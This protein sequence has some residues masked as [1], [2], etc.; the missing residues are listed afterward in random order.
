[1][2]ILLIA[3][4]FLICPNYLFAQEDTYE[5]T[6]AKIDGVRY[7]AIYRSSD[8]SISILNADGKTVLHLKNTDYY[9][10]GFSSFKFVDFNGDGYKDLF[11]EHMSNVPG[12]CDLLLYDSRIKKFAPV[13]DFPDYPDPQKLK[14]THLYY[15]YHRSGCADMNWDS[16]L[17]KIV[18]N[19]II[20]IGNISGLGCERDKKMG[21][22]IS[23][24]NGKEE[25]QIQKYPIGEIEKYKDYKWGFIKKY[26]ERNSRKFI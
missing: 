3:V 7:K 6:S 22:F 24:I 19:K 25:R 15:S 13:K 2:K 16:D 5:T 1:M 9:D 20:K 10:E 4:A 12:R 18:N 26:W 14:G 21:I 17:F 11:I 8:W 23:K